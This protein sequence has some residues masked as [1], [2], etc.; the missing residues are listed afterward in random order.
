M[1]HK[2][3]VFRYEYACIEAPGNTPE[4]AVGNA[5]EIESTEGAVWVKEQLG[6][7]PETE[8]KPMLEPQEVWALQER[9]TKLEANIVQLKEW[10]QEQKSICPEYKEP[11]KTDNV[12]EF[13]IRALMELIEKI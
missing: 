3:D 2:I 4:E 13:H 8:H 1:T 6:F 9:N 12:S 11:P 5:I 7:I 10:V